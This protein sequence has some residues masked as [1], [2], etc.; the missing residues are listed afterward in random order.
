VHPFRRVVVQCLFALLLLGAGHSRA[1]EPAELAVIYPASTGPYQDVFDGLLR[2]I[3][4]NLGIYGLS[5][6][7]IPAGG[8]DVDLKRWLEKAAPTSLI[9][10]GRQAYDEV[11][12]LGYGDKTIAGALDL[13]PSRDPNA[14]GVSLAVDPSQFFAILKKLKPGITRVLVVYDPAKNQWVIDKARAISPQYGLELVSF[15]ATDIATAAQHYR[16]LLQTTRPDLDALWIPLD[17]ALIDEEHILPVI[18]EQSWYR[19]L[20]VFSNS[21]LHTKYGALFAI[22]P[23]PDTLGAHLVD[24]ALHPGN[25]SP[26]I[27]LL[28]DVHRALNLRFARH[29]DID[30]RRVSDDFDTFFPAANP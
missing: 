13:S 3:H 28:Q 10:L 11:R 23:D 24:K 29:L 26:P 4:R 18:T 21:V 19:R 17:S 6:Y 27:E 1:E 20:V 5:T 14:H 2:G 9:T 8:T 25:N 22:Y 7:V 16:A 15:S 30:I 12:R